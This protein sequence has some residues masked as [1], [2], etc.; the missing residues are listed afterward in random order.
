MTSF[1]RH[2]PVLR[3]NQSLLLDPQGRWG[4]YEFIRRIPQQKGRTITSYLH[5]SIYRT[6]RT[7]NKQ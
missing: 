1:A 7:E 4:V 3:L 6:K 5:S 2:T